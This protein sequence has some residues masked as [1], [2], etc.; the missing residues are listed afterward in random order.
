VLHAVGIHQA[1][2]LG[3]DAR[4]EEKTISRRFGHHPIKGDIGQGVFRISSPDVRV[5]AGEPDLTQP[6]IGLLS[7]VPQKRT[8][9]V[10]LVV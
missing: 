4:L 6:V 9:C 10:P 2:D 8:E 1:P 7:L 5:Y 3:L